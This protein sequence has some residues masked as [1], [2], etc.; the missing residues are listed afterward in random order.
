MLVCFVSTYLPQRCGIAT[1][2]AALAQALAK[3]GEQELRVISER[4]SLDGED[5][6]V[7][8]VPSFDRRRDYGADIVRQAVQL[9]AEVLHVQHAPDIFG[10]D[11]RIIEMVH[12]LRERRIRC[13]VT[14]HTVHS[15]RSGLVE[16][17]FGVARFHRR[18]AESVDRIV[19]HGGAAMST[20]LRRQGVDPLKI[21]EISHG[22]TLHEAVD[23]A[24]CRAALGL[25]A[26][27]KLMLFLGFIHPQKNLHTV[28]L[29]MGSVRRNIGNARL[30]IAGSLQNRAWYNRA[31]LR[32]LR[33]LIARQSLGD[34]VTLR[35]EF[36][37]SDEATLLYGAADLVL[38]PYAQGYGSASGIAHHALGAYRVPLCSQS[39]KFAEIGSEIEPELLVR[40]HSP[41]AWSTAITKL[42]TNDIWRASLEKRVR[43][44]ARTTAW[45]EVARQHRQLYQSL[46]RPS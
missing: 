9:G 41:S 27:E 8:S 13:V 21:C 14:L 2:T 46:L 35:E 23:R 18:L 44:Y 3:V 33:A 19:V 22:T 16:R 28:L 32:G 29:A 11:E 1:Y 7:V 45:A 25:A 34:C 20:E 37:P 6:G 10:M 15:A 26:D 17:R 5:R 31:Y 12:Q 4:G 24:H 30:Y 36:V 43:H 40:T 42:L 38:L 39:P